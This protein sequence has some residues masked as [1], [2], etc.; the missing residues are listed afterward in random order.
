MLITFWS[1]NGIQK[2]KFEGI[3]GLAFPE[4]S[5]VPGTPIFDHMVL[6]NNMRHKEFA[7]YIDEKDEVSYRARINKRN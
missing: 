5:S 6:L 7:F 1:K 3:V 2:I 4:M